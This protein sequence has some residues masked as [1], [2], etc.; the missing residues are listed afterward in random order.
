[1]DTFDFD[2]ANMDDFDDSLSF[3]DFVGL[4][5]P[6]AGFFGESPRHSLP[7]CSHPSRYR[8]RTNETHGYTCTPYI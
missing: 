4:D 6:D 3:A 7:N 1:M 8:D 5:A 2:G